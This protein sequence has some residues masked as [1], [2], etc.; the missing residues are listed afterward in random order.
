MH[1]KWDIWTRKWDFY[2]HYFQWEREVDPN[3]SDRQQ[4]K[5]IGVKFK[6]SNLK[7]APVNCVRIE[8][9]DY[10]FIIINVSPFKID[11]FFSSAEK[12][13]ANV[14]KVMID[15]R[16]KQYLGPGESY[17]TSI[18]IQIEHDFLEQFAVLLDNHPDIKSLLSGELIKEIENII[19]FV[20]NPSSNFKHIIPLNNL[21]NELILDDDKSNPELNDSMEL[22]NYIDNLRKNPVDTDIQ[23]KKLHGL[24]AKGENPNKCH[25]GVTSLRLLI[26]HSYNYKQFLIQL[27][28]LMVT[29]GARAELPSPTD[30]VSAVEYAFAIGNFQVVDFFIALATKPVQPPSAAS[31]L[32]TADTHGARHKV[33]STFRFPKG[34]LYTTLKRMDDLTN[35]DKDE[36]INLYRKRRLTGD[37]LLTFS[38]GK[39]KFIDIIRNEGGKIVGFVIHILRFDKD[40]LWC[41]VD[42]ELFDCDYSNYGIMPG[43][44]Y[45]FPFSLQLLYPKLTVWIVFFSAHWCS[46][47]RIKDELAVPMYISDPVV[48]KLLDALLKLYAYKFI[49]HYNAPQEF[50]IIEEH[51]TVVQGEH[52]SAIPGLKEELYH[53]YRGDNGT[54]PPELIKQRDVLVAL[55]ST[56]NFMKTLHNMLAFKGMNFLCNVYEL[57]KQLTV[58]GLFEAS[59][60]VAEQRFVE[61]RYIFW[62]GIKVPAKAEVHRELASMPVHKQNAKPRF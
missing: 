16:I 46:F 53:Q 4:F 6:Y 50:Y 33:I 19:A 22:I 37:A 59:E 60:P 10:L 52:R 43:I 38:A 5:C 29:Y 62:Q 56:I 9:R 7:F 13:F 14:R 36:L 49:L 11:G 47:N 39:N 23:I 61:G 40:I 54:I 55:P 58:S 44:T 21:G 17:G 20:A 8:L 24:L 12:L 57:A 3:D 35:E 30:K 42:L 34:E 18:R 26:T 31:L 2:S 41:N 1:K 32:Y 48:E 25:N 51:P 27:C 45:R 28:K 15:G